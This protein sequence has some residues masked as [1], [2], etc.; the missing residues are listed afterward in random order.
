MAKAEQRRVART[1]FVEEGRNRKEIALKLNVREKTVGDWASEGNW[2]TLRNE[3]LLSSDNAVTTLRQLVSELASKRLEMN[4]DPKATAE[5]KRGVTDE[6]S[7][8]TKALSEAKGEGELTLGVRLKVMEWVF[9]EM[10]KSHRA[11]HDQL[12]DFQEALLEDAARLHA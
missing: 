9:S 11:Q 5:E 8:A 6:L 3:R 4:R 7:K 10:R 2:E 1:L 12:I